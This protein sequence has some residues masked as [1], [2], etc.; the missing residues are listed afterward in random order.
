MK[1]STTVPP[2]RAPLVLKWYINDAGQLTSRWVGE[3]ASAL[4]APSQLPLAG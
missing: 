2:T 4:V 1:R 3:E